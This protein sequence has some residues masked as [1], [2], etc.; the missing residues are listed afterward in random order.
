MGILNGR[1]K[2]KLNDIYEEIYVSAEKINWDA[3]NPKMDMA[4][5]SLSDIEK[6]V[7]KKFKGHLGKIINSLK[8]MKSDIRNS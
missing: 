2:D 6:L 8:A 1:E 5:R 4:I 3:I 7:G